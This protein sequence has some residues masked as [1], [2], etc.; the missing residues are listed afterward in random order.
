M[1][2]ASKH[3]TNMEILSLLSNLYI[4]TDL[5]Q[6]GMKYSGDDSLLPCMT[7]SPLHVYTAFMNIYHMV[8]WLSTYLNN[9]GC[10]F[11]STCIYPCNLFINVCCS[12]NKSFILHICMNFA[13]ASLHQFTFQS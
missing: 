9:G 2:S 12:E 1:L 10:S 3:C 13:E 7:A 4:G 6:A 5:K 11:K 8:Y